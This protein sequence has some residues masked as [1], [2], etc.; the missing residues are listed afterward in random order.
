MQDD[1]DTLLEHGHAEDT[2]EAR[3]ETFETLDNAVTF[4]EGTLVSRPSAS[5]AG[6][7]YYA[8]DVGRY[9]QDTGSA[10]ETVLTAGAW[11]Y[12]GLGTYVSRTTEGPRR[13]SRPS[14]Y[15]GGSSCR[16]CKCPASWS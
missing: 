4:S 12:L 14:S 7:V 10:W 16:A 3:V 2:I 6:R 8:T 1:T 15:T 13:D 11:T 5:L 9:Y